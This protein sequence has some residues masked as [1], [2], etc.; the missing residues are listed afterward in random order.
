M[1]KSMEIF[2]G[3]VFEERKMATLRR[4]HDVQVNPSQQRVEE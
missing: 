3:S 4:Y 1:Q 2:P